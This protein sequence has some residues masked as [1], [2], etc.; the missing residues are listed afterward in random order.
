M[1]MG[2]MM[3]QWHKAS[4]VSFKNKQVAVFQQFFL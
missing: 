1:S 3:K 4:Q 2:G